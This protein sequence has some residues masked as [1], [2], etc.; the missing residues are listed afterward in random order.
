MVIAEFLTPQE[1]AQE[2]R[3]GL[4]TVHNWLK[5]G[6][7][8]GVKVGGKLWRVRREDYERFLAREV[9]EA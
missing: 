5:R 1:I 4:F 7:L 2:M 9:T 3:V 8:T 6:D